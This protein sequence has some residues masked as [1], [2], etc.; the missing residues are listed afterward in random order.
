MTDAQLLPRKIG[1]YRGQCAEFCGVQHAKMAL[2]VTVESKA[3]FDRWYA[4]QLRPA[5]VPLTRCSGR[6]TPLH[7]S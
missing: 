4:A 7:H 1:L 2:D 3:D 6:A 5:P